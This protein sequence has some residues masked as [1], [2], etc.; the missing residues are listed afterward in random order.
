MIRRGVTDDLLA[1]VYPLLNVASWLAVA[2]SGLFH[3]QAPQGTVP[4]YGVLQA[5]MG[6][7]ALPTMSVPGEEVRFQL[8]GVS[9]GLDYA[10]ALAIIKAAVPLLENAQPAIANHFV[11]RIWWESTQVYPD[12]E[13]VNGIPVWHAVGQWCSLIEQVS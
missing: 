13:M 4:P 7:V 11:L 12:P 2:T 1:A 8:R 6:V 10:E 3:A 9:R 5:P